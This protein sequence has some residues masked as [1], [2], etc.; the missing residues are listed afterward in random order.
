MW[1]ALL[2]DLRG[3]VPR[4]VV[5]ARFHRGL[6]RAIREMVVRL[7][8]DRERPRFDT[9]ALSG[10]CFQNR[11]L[12]EETERCLSDEGL[13]VLSHAAVP[14]NDG[15]IA[16]GQAAIAAARLLGAKGASPALRAQ[17][18]ARERRKDGRRS[19]IAG[20]GY[21]RRPKLRA[22]ATEDETP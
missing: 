2:R 19:E 1:R 5:A 9:L 16:L 15:G 22:A 7:R 4:G 12:F 6:A 14:P 20:V 17:R 13:V 21:A 8:G 11:V 10:G 3:G 18:S